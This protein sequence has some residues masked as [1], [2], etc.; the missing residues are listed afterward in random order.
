MDVPLRY[1]DVLSVDTA[2]AAAEHQKHVEE[3][4]KSPEEIAQLKRKWVY[5]GRMAEREK[6]P[7][8][9]ED[10]HNEEREKAL[11]ELYQWAKSEG[12]LCES[13]G[14]L[15]LESVYWERIKSGH[16]PEEAKE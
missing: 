8:W 4:Y 13:C 2:I 12:F 16:L 6:M 9:F 14:T 10:V 5:E 1:I 7:K 11:R 3:G 15:T